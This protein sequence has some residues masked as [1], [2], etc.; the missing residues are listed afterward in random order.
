MKTN[1]CQSPGRFLSPPLIGIVLVG[2]ICGA[3][4]TAAAA[5]APLVSIV[6]IVRAG[7][8]DPDGG[9]ILFDAFGGP[10]LND[11]GELVFGGS[12]GFLGTDSGIFRTTIAGELTTIARGGVEP[13][14]GNG[15]FDGTRSGFVNASPQINAAGQVLF[16]G[17]ILNQQ[18]GSLESSGWFIG[19]GQTIT[20][21]YRSNTF[22]P[23]GGVF[24]DLTAA[25]SL[26]RHGQIAFSHIYDAPPPIEGRAAFQTTPTGGLAVVARAG[27]T[28]P[29]L[30]PNPTA[31]GSEKSAEL[32]SPGVN[33]DIA[34]DSFGR[35]TFLTGLRDPDFGNF[36][37]AAIYQTNGPGGAL[38]RRVSTGD[39]LPGGGVYEPRALGG[40]N[41]SGQVA[42]YGFLSEVST[43]GV[44]R[45]LVL[46]DA[47]GQ[48][49]IASTDQ[50]P[51]GSSEFFSNFGIPAINASGQAV[52]FG[53]LG[54]NE[55][56]G[57]YF[58]DGATY[59][60]IAV[61][62]DALPGG[63]GTFDSFGS[64]VINDHG[65]VMFIASLKDVPN[66]PLGS[67]IYLFDPRLGIVKVAQ[68]GDLLA[69]DEIGSVSLA[70][71]LPRLGLNASGLNQR[72]QVAFRY[73]ALDGET[74]N[75][76]S[77]VALFTLPEALPLTDG[78]FSDQTL[79]SWAANGNVVAAPA[80]VAGDS[81]PAA[82][83]TTASP[84]GISRTIETPDLPFL[85][86]YETYFN[87]PEGLLTVTLDG[88]VIDSL[89]ASTT[90]AFIDRTILIEDP[91]L[92]G[93][94]LVLDFS[95]DTPLPGASVYLDNIGVVPEP[96][97]LA[98]LGLGGL[99]IG[100]RRARR[101][102]A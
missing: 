97:S 51:P 100:S 68:T 52:F 2:G 14:N 70:N 62:G 26:N 30:I 90:L 60:E 67:G 84:A 34:L 28:S 39:A 37:G 41:D 4:N 66:H 71:D 75:L 79:G 89:E 69:G 7:D 102:V 15:V 98:L 8:A 29:Y 47:S 36:V 91:S 61:T 9:P 54:A 65:Q 10:V 88:Q 6:P 5:E 45:A 49:V 16:S 58:R 50:R 44:H 73:D 27:A 46:S 82:L 85:L 76:T 25:P 42:S 31:P 24:Q 35:S 64:P 38:I 33:G 57:I 13:P 55:S 83:L 17:N 99:A 74:G 81:D 59:Q 95:F 72:G 12:F 3:P 94:D 23:G 86:T 21:G 92:L 63:G 19:D 77:G 53:T 96:T 101:Q 48:T 43:P 18:G 78:A 20:R 32:R 1:A 80:A 93:G 87:Q 22:A 11:S 40:V 56:S